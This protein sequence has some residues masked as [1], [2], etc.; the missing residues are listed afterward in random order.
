VFFLLLLSIPVIHPSPYIYQTSGHVTEAQIEGYGTAFSYSHEEI[1]YSKVRSSPDRYGDAIYGTTDKSQEYY[2]RGSSIT[3]PDH[4][5]NQNLRS[6]FE[7]PEYLA[8]TEAD[9]VR[10]GDVYKGFRFGSQDFRYVN[11]EPGI[12]KIQSNGGLDI[13][14]INPE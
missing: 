1:Y 9:R 3:V 8:I 14:L 10:D 12:D 13:Y 11:N 7:D 5:A 6:Y 4:F 2:R